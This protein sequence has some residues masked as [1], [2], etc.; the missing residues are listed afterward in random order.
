MGGSATSAPSS[1]RSF[2]TIGRKKT[3]ETEFK[4]G[5]G[6]SLIILANFHLPAHSIHPHSYCSITNSRSSNPYKHH[7]FQPLT[8]LLPSPS[9][10]SLLARATRSSEIRLVHS[11]PRLESPPEIRYCRFIDM[12]FCWVDLSFIRVSYRE[13]KGE[14]RRGKERQNVHVIQ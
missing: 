5:I 6:N 4:S 7:K 3:A 12:S 8:M 11:D 2:A 10:N 9:P 13:G 14:G 1:S